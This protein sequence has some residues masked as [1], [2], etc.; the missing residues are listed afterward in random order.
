MHC[1]YFNV[2]LSLKFENKLITRKKKVM[3]RDKKISNALLSILNVNLK[4]NFI[5][6]YREHKN[7]C[8]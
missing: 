7:S 5:N 1:F 3:P 6:K 8:S 4:F 2:I